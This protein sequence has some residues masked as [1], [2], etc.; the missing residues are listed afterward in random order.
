MTLALASKAA[1][2]LHIILLVSVRTEFIL[3]FKAFGLGLF[4][5]ENISFY[6]LFLLG[7][8]LRLFTPKVYSF[9]FMPQPS[10]LAL[11]FCAFSSYNSIP[12]KPRCSASTSVSI[13]NCLFKLVLAESTK[14]LYNKYWFYT[15]YTPRSSASVVCPTNT[16]LYFISRPRLLLSFIT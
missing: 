4:Y 7:L 12:V 16:I 11:R 9:H 6:C 10:A 2:S 8:R 3:I 13:M 1:A 5:T 15:V 14:M